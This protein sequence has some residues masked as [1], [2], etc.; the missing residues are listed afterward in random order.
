M[1]TGGG[2]INKIMIDSRF[3]TPTS[4]SN[5]NFSIELNENILLPERT[6]CIIT[7]VLIPRTWYA[8][9]STNNNIYFRI[10]KASSTSDYIA[11]LPTQ[12]Y[13]LFELT[14]AILQA[15]YDAA[16][17]DY[18]T[19]EASTSSGKIRLSIKDTS[20]LSF[21]IF[22]DADLQSRCNDTW[23][24]G[25]Y[26]ADNIQSLNSVIRNDTNIPLQ[27][28]TSSKPFYT[29]V[30]DL[31]GAHTLYITSTALTTYNNI[32]SRG[33]RNILKKVLCNVPFGELIIDYT[34]LEKDYTDV[35]NRALKILDFRLVDVYGND[36]D[37]NGGHISFSVLFVDI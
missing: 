26:S 2:Y 32:G 30:V 10:T 15:M 20:V 22:T 25:Y 11:T 1:S 17:A 13:T 29:G 5:T 36:I 8:I 21:C 3:K 9:N 24:G 19:G 28:Y 37:L 18:F 12:N 7:D 27:A 33:E 34:Y 14:S 31:V 23:S 16:D 6:G 35:S 4:L